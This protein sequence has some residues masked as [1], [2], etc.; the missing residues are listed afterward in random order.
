MPLSRQA[1]SAFADILLLFIIVFSSLIAIVFSLLLADIDISQSWLRLK[2]KAKTT[3]QTYKS[4]S[5]K[6]H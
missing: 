1:A 3:K 2:L 4:H 5:W 6:H